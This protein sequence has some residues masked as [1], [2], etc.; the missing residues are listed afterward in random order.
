LPHLKTYAAAAETADGWADY[1]AR[2]VDIDAGHL[3]AEAA[4]G[5]DRIRALPKPIY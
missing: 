1:R 4:G 2:F 3:F 5:A